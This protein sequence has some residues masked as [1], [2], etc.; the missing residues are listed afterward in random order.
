MTPIRK[1]STRMKQVRKKHRHE[2]SKWWWVVL[3]EQWERLC[4]SCGEIQN[5]SGAKKP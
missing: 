3:K 5:K 1:E 2:W 4:H